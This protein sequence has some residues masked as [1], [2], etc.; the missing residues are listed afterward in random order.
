MRKLIYLF[1]YPL[2]AQPMAGE[3]QPTQLIDLPQLVAENVTIDHEALKQC[4]GYFH[5]FFTTLHPQSNRLPLPQGMDQRDHEKAQQDSEKEFDEVHQSK[6]DMNDVFRAWAEGIA[7]ANGN[8]ETDLMK[9]EFALSI[10][11]YS[12]TYRGLFVQGSTVSHKD[13]NAYHDTLVEHERACT[14]IYDRYSH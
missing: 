3:T 8:L 7:I 1:A 6:S 13:P 2:L 10:I 12:Q 5:Y 14:A 9:H 4:A 11:K